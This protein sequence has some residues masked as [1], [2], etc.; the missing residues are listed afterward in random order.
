MF[1]GHVNAHD[2][3]SD[4][5]HPNII[6]PI[7]LL[8]EISKDGSDS[9]G[10]CPDLRHCSKKPYSHTQIYICIYIYPLA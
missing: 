4:L 6:T 5:E 3:K 1:G 9:V 7:V 8:M 2:G 10:W